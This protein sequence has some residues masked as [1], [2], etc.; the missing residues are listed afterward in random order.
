M[1]VFL[2]SKATF[3]ANYLRTPLPLSYK[4][5][6]ICIMSAALG[7]AKAANKKYIGIEISL[8]YS[9]IPYL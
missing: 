5:A 8:K 6:M 3:A 2:R 4:G 7:I 1:Y 9:G